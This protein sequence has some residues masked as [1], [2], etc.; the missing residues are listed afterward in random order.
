MSLQTSQMVTLM[1]FDVEGASARSFLLFVSV[2][3]TISADDEGAV[4]VY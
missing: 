3:T 1:S 4:S 2:S